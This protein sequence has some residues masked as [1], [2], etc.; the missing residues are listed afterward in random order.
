MPKT[1][2]FSCKYDSF[3]FIYT[4]IL[5]DNIKKFS[6]FENNKILYCLNNKAEKLLELN[7]TDKKERFWNI[8]IKYLN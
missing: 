2:R 4:N 7:E 3:F 1:N 8:I 6:N 5:F